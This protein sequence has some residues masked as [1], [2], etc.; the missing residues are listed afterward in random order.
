MT[1]TVAFVHS[2]AHD[3]LV[4]IVDPYLESMRIG[5]AFGA[6]GLNPASSSRALELTGADD[7][8]PLSRS[9]VPSISLSPKA[10]LQAPRH[11]PIISRDPGGLSRQSRRGSRA[12]ERP[13]RKGRVLRVDS[14]SCRQD[15]DVGAPAPGRV[16]RPYCRAC[17]RP[18]MG[19]WQV[20]ATPADDGSRAIGQ[21]PP[22]AR[23]LVHQS[24]MTAPPCSRARA[25]RA[26]LCHSLTARN[27]FP[28]S[29]EISA[30]TISSWT[31][32]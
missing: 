21:L 15:R 17:A 4:Q 23:R 8:I 7:R 32:T 16:S 6:Y 25:R 11:R 28:I 5:R 13:R 12:R 27:A 26:L 19:C 18:A 20:I 9:V 31:R 24:P 3:I 22:T 14:E 30:C 1:P 29:S 10:V 2:Q